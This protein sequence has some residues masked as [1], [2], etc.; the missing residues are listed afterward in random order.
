MHAEKCLLRSSWVPV[1]SSAKGVRQY[2]VAVL[3]VCCSCHGCYTYFDVQDSRSDLLYCS[4]TVMAQSSIVGYEACLCV[5]RLALRVCGVLT[6]PSEC[7]MQQGT[8]AQQY[9]DAISCIIR[10]GLRMAWRQ[11]HEHFCWRF[12]I[13]NKNWYIRT[14]SR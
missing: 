14:L 10:V 3:L 2:F 9:I 11:I 4:R 12:P 13:G 8:V 7:L 6:E 5:T 1:F